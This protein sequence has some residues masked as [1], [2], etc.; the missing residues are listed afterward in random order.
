MQERKLDHIGK[1]T[2]ISRGVDILHGQDATIILFEGNFFIFKLLGRLS[3]VTDDRLFIWILR[4]RHLSLLSVVTLLDARNPRI[5]GVPN[6][7]K[8]RLLVSAHDV[9]FRWFSLFTL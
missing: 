3:S 4:N 9:G 2:K 1:R 8:R 7:D 6:E 5:L